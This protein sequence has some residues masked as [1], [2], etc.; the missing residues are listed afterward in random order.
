[1]CYKSILKAVYA[2]SVILISAVFSTADAQNHSGSSSW[3]V[4]LSGGFLNGTLGSGD[5]YFQ[6]TDTPF[7]FEQDYFLSKSVNIRFD[8][9]QFEAIQANL[10]AGNF[11]VLSIYEPWPELSFT[12]DFYTTSLSAHL[13]LLRFFKTPP[14]MLSLYGKFG[15]GLMF[16]NTSVTF[17]DGPE[18][19]EGESDRSQHAFYVLGGGVK[20]NLIPRLALF[21]GYDYHLSNQDII[22]N[23]YISEFIDSDFNKTTSNWSAF[24]VGL[25]FTFSRN[26]S[27]TA[28]QVSSSGQSVSYADFFEAVRVS[29]PKV[30]EISL[31][32]NSEKDQYHPFLERTVFIPSAKPLFGADAADGPAVAISGQTFGLYGNVS[33]QHTQ[34]YTIVVHSLRDEHVAHS[35]A[36]QIRSEGFRA[37]V[38]TQRING[39]QYYRVALGQFRTPEDA[40]EAAAALPS[41]YRDQHFIQPLP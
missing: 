19:T 23:N 28:G 13:N 34:G 7:E 18:N 32:K 14:D 30:E 35:T 24:S 39:E 1:M 38:I 29:S 16:N 20:M 17:Q 26:R 6:V 8:L 36:G 15:F 25:Q 2:L 3:S 21:I 31:K 22:S 11:T 10:S 27:R 40:R 33:G 9:N 5:D 12:N 41:S 4:G 37:F